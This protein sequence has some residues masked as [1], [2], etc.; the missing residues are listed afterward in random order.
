MLPISNIFI[1]QPDRSPHIYLQPVILSVALHPANPVSWNRQTAYSL[2][3]FSNFLNDSSEEFMSVSRCRY[4]VDDR[5]LMTEMYRQ[6]MLKDPLFQF[7][8]TI[9]CHGGYDYDGDDFENTVHVINYQGRRWHG[10]S[11]SFFDQHV[12]QAFGE[13]IEK[14]KADEKKSIVL[15]FGDHLPSLSDDFYNQLLGEKDDQEKELLLHE[16]PYLFWANYDVSLMR[17]QK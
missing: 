1:A 4:W 3:G 17:F 10:F 15:M 2:L 14:L 5:A 13:L 9:Q 12:D 11:V 6:S 8:L 7:G 16:T